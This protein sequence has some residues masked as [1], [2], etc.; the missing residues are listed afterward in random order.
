ML[1]AL[2]IIYFI[3]IFISIT[4]EIISVI[5]ILKSGL[6]GLRLKII[7]TQLRK[8]KLTQLTLI[9]TIVSDLAIWPIHFLVAILTYFIYNFKHKPTQQYLQGLTAYRCLYSTKIITLLCTFIFTSIITIIIYS[10]GLPPTGEHKF[11]AWIIIV[12]CLTTSAPIVIRPSLFINQ[13]GQ[14]VVNNNLLITVFFILLGAINIIGFIIVIANE[15][16]DILNSFIITLK[17]NSINIFGL[18]NNGFKNMPAT[19]ILMATSA[20]CYITSI[21]AVANVQWDKKAK[22]SGVLERA[23]NYICI[24]KYSKAY[25][26]VNNLQEIKTSEL[27]T[28]KVTILVALGRIQEAI[29]FWEQIPVSKPYIGTKYFKEIQL[30]ELVTSLSTYNIPEKEVKFFVKM[31]P[32]LESYSG[33]YLNALKQ[34]Y[35]ELAFTLTPTGSILRSIELEFMP[36]VRKIYN[37]IINLEEAT[38]PATIFKCILLGLF[39]TNQKVSIQLDKG[40]NI[41]I[42]ANDFFAQKIELILIQI[43]KLD[44]SELNFVIQLVLIK[45]ILIA[46]SGIITIPFKTLED[47]LIIELRKE[48][49]KSLENNYITLKR[50]LNI[51]T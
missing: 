37:D 38:I 49:R 10:S 44:N 14:S 7:L 5:T 47:K 18:W 39:I 16:I 46:N 15:P 30:L 45:H 29:Q 40:Y 17:L 23:K 25:K 13:I 11:I 4:I 20:I 26:I 48:Y 22:N 27:G 19:Y 31:I 43:D 21:M 28:L 35:K 9:I 32:K 34:N 2:Y 51:R 8:L 41:L 3:G 50:V 1:I 6:Q 42:K 33:F 36:N 12:Y 24:G